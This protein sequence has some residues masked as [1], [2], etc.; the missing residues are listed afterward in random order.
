[1]WLVLLL[2]LVWVQRQHWISRQ[3]RHLLRVS[4]CHHSML[5]L[6]D[7]W[8]CPVASLRR[9]ELHTSLLPA[10]KRQVKNTNGSYYKAIVV[11]QEKSGR[12]L[13]ALS[14]A[15]SNFYVWRL[16]FNSELPTYFRWEGMA[17]FHL[18]PERGLLGPNQE[19]YITVVFQPQEALVYQ[20]HASCRFGEECENAQS[21]CTVLLQG[22]GMHSKTVR[23]KY[24]SIRPCDLALSF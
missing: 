4:P 12:R 5:R 9:S 6:R 11:Q 18:N 19:R 22:V 1:M 8:I 2:L 24:T 20:E 13:A 7:A 16:P 15:E 17:P 23:S 21:S 3:G 14:N 10:P